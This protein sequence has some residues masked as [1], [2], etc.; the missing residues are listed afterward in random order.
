MM[1]LVS[2]DAKVTSENGAKRLRDIAKECLN[3]GQR[4]Q[5]SVFECIL[6]PAQWTLLKNRLES[7]INKE[8]DSLRYY[9][10]GSNWNRKIG[11]FGAKKPRD[12]TAP[13]I[14]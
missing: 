12:F 5:F 2:Y 6:E 10:L 11:H 13:I 8:T 14:I 1:V 9:Y 7:I 3:Y 4:V